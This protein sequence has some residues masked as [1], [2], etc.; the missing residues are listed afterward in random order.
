MSSLQYNVQNNHPIIPNVNEYFLEQ[1]YISIHSGDRD[2]KKYPVS[3]EFEIEL[4]EDYLNVQSLQLHS[5]NFPTSNLYVFSKL[6]NNVSMVFSVMP[7]TVKS[8]DTNSEY[9]NYVYDCL[10]KEHLFVIEIEDGTY[11][12]LQ[13]STELTNRFNTAVSIYLYEYFQENNILKYYQPYNE[14]VI[15]YNNVSQKMWFG[16]K[17]SSFVLHNDDTSLDYQHRCVTKNVF[18]EYENWG[19]PFNLGFTKTTETSI[20]ALERL[21]FYYGDVF[22][23]DKGYWITPNPDLSNSTVYYITS[24]I[25]TNLLGPNCFYMELDKQNYIDETSPYRLNNF[26]KTT[27]ITNG[28]VNSSFAVIYFDP[29]NLDYQWYNTHKQPMKTYHPPAERIRRFSFRFRYHNGMLVDF[30]NTEFS[31]TIQL[32]LLRPQNKTGYYISKL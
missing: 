2:V 18:P 3:T 5:W 15:V 4:P 8:T 21:R 28:E 20:Q 17:S 9:Y 7:C 27:N 19:L 30:G 14:F 26:T 10:S 13:L 25:K 29:K 12:P 1:K 23:N 22:E 11:T 6:Q 24:P 31:F 32:T 16:N